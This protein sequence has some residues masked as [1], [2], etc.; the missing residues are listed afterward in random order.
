MAKSFYSSYI[1]K[2]IKNCLKKESLRFILI[3]I[4][5]TLGSYI[6]Y[7]FLLLFLDYLLSYTL[8]LILFIIFSSYLNTSFVFKLKP[9]INTLISFLILIIIQ[10]IIGGLI[11]RYAVEVLLIPKIYAPFLSLFFITPF[12]YLTSKLLKNYIKY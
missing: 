2:S 7:C 11:V 5:N 1:K 12:K 4:F 6:V 10:L 9:T 8:S 3:G